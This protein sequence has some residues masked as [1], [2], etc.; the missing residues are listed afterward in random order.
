MFTIILA[1]A[2]FVRS[3]DAYEALKGFQLLQLPSRATQQAYTGSFIDDL[4]ICYKC[5]IVFHVPEVCVH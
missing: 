3:P 4:G 5:K 2:V 1:L